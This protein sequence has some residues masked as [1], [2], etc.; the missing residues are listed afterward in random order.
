[1]SQNCGLLRMQEQQP[2]AGGVA[3]TCGDERFTVPQVLKSIVSLLKILCFDP[4]SIS[5]S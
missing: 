1:M 5:L 2:G 4:L 3:G